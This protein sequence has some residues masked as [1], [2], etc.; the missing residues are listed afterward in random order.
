MNAGADYF[1]DKTS[2]FDRIVDVLKTTVKPGV[3]AQ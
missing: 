3:A 1:F 2:E